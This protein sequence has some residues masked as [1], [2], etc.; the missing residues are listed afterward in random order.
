MAEMTNQSKQLWHVS[1]DVTLLSASCSTEDA[2][3]LQFKC[4]AAGN[5]GLVSGR[6]PWDVSRDPQYL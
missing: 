3:V 2:C 1:H 6:R 5:L 4:T